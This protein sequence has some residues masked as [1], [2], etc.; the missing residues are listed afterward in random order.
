MEIID[1]LD[2]GAELGPAASCFIMGERSWSY[3]TVRMQTLK[4]AS[5]ISRDHWPAGA[6]VATLSPNDPRA[7]ICVLGALRAHLVWLPVNP[8]NTV[9]DT[10]ELL[11]AFDCEILFLHSDFE[12]ALLSI[13]ERLPRIR[14]I[15]AIDR[16]FGGLHTVDSWLGDMEALAPN[17]A[18]A[19]TDD[20]VAIIA[21]GGTT[22][23]PKGVVQTHR[24]FETYVANHVTT[25]WQ[26]GRPRYLVAAPMTHAAGFMCFPML[27]RGGTIVVLQN[28]QPETVAAA[29]NEH[30]ITDLFLPPTVIYMMLGHSV[31]RAA[32]FPSLKYLLYGAAPMSTEKLKEALQLFGPVLVQGYGQVE[33]LMLCTV[34]MPDDHFIDGV[35]ADDKRLS[36]CGRPAPFCNLA[37]MDEK[38]GLLSTGETGELVVRA[39]NVMKGYYKDPEATA[40]A[41]RFGWHHTGDIGFRDADGYFHLVDRA[42]DLIISGGFNIFPSEIEQVLWSHPCVQDCAVIGVPHEKWGEAVTAIIELKPGHSVS[43]RELIALCK[44]RLGS[45]KAPKS[46][47]V[48]E[49]LPRSV[50]GKV[51]KRQIR[52]AFWS[53]VNRRI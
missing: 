51:L 22:G 8:R 6:K 9:D 23:R 11:D 17:S 24:C 40:E 50:V 46:V 30:Q 20:P 19:S 4:I 26:D 3:E 44:R 2:R 28:A 14:L 53:Q 32:K 41:S 39:G 1:Y 13:R 35:V 34:L 49:E 12:H 33:A 38:G 47:M 15:V 21:T 16:E 48:W 29:I 36:S 31:V 10:I 37:V 7:F 43:E 52:D 25:M 45:I 42:R 27:A 5:A 18:P